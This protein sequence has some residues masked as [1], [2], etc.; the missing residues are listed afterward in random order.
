LAAASKGPYIA[1]LADDDLWDRYHLE[2]AWRCLEKRPKVVA[3]FGQAVCVDNQNCQPFSRFSG[4]F[5]HILSNEDQKLQDYFFWDTALMAANSLVSTPLN[6]WAGVI[7][8]RVHRTALEESTGHP[9]FGKLAANDSLYIWRLSTYGLIACGRH[10]SLFYR[11]HNQSDLQSQAR[12]D[13]DKL[14]VDELAIRME[15]ARQ[16]LDLG[17]NPFALWNQ[18]FHIAGSQHLSHRI[19]RDEGLVFQWLKHE[20]NTR[21]LSRQEDTQS[22]SAIKK[23]IKSFLLQI[24]PPI[25]TKLCK[26]GQRT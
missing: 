12:A 23:T 24:T 14:K 13:H 26:K 21:G 17:K 15:I 2:E 18:L 11:V 3:Y 19:Y 10:I 22:S 6:I 7:E 8:S 16:A 9:D 5:N 1:Q 25:L 20:L 4:N